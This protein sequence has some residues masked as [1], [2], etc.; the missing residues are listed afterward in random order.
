MTTEEY[1]ELEKKYM[2]KKE[3]IIKQQ[4]VI[5]NKNRRIFLLESE[6]DKLKN[7]ANS[8]VGLEEKQ[9]QEIISPELSQYP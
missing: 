6:L 5:K 4:E 1:E 7:R 3:K 9:S 2:E 8:T